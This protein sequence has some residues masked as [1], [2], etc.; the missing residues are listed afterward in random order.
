MVDKNS[1]KQTRYQVTV[2]GDSK[3]GAKTRRKANMYATSLSRD[4]PGAVV[5]VV[6]TMPPE[7]KS[8]AIEGD[9]FIMAQEVEIVDPNNRQSKIIATRVNRDVISTLY[10]Q[11]LITEAQKLAADK[12][13]HAHIVCQGQ[14][15]MAV[16]Y[17]KDRVDVSGVSQSLTEAQIHAMQIITQSTKELTLEDAL[18]VQKIVGEGFTIKQYC[19]DCHKG[20]SYEDF[21]AKQRRLLREN[22]TQL[23]ILWGYESKARRA[24]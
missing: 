1:N 10:S 12:Y 17:E 19:N 18:R 4:N 22:L 16:D 13:Y 5:E 9:G 8:K 6:D 20:R 2:N 14:T 23:A 15:N 24:A 7:K 21:R 11:R 3:I